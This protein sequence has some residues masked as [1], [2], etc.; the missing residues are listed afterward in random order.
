MVE[1]HEAPK[2]NENA[3][4]SWDRVSANY[5]QSLG[6]RL[7]RG[8]QFSESDNQSK[9]K[10][11]NATVK[12]TPDTHAG[13]SETECK[14]SHTIMMTIEHTM[15]ISE[16]LAFV[17]LKEVIPDVGEHMRDVPLLSG[18]VRLRRIACGCGVQL[19]NKYDVLLRQVVTQRLHMITVLRIGFPTVRG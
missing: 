2:F 3:G 6:L 7:V 15:N 1:G 11:E 4:A 18:T 8:R 9:P 16:V 10:R 13:T 12:I 14:N 5:L 19:C 17:W